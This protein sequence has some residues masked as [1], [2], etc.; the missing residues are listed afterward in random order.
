MAIRT[1]RN[2]LVT[3]SSILFVLMIIELDVVGLFGA[4]DEH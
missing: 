4:V 1:T 2:I 3:F